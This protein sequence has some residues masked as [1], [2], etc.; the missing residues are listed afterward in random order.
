MSVCTWM[1]LRQVSDRWVTLVRLPRP[2]S[3]RL[4]LTVEAAAELARSHSCRT[5]SSVDFCSSLLSSF[6][7]LTDRSSG[8]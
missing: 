2:P 3:V 4:V 7:L 6:I 5:L 8:S 1:Q